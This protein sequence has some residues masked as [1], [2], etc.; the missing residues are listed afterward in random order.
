MKTCTKCKREIPTDAFY[1]DRRRP[2]GRM[3]R[4]KQCKKAAYSRWYAMHPDINQKRYKENRDR[5]RDR[6]LI[7][8]YGI[9]GVGYAS[10]LR[11][12]GGVCKICGAKE[13]AH[14]RL[15]VDHDHE[16]GKVRGLLCA[17]CNQLLGYAHDDLAVLAAAIKYLEET[18]EPSKC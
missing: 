2:N 13:P 7:K 17:T 9:D 8:K 16:T 14:K 18:K 1:R 3:S 6:H 15:D 11:R 4:C 10:L 12:Q 5:E